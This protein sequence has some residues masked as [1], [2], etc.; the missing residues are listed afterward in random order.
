VTTVT[1]TQTGLLGKYQAIFA[2]DGFL[3]RHNVERREMIELMGLSTL[4]G[5]DPLFLGDPGVGKTWAI[6]LLTE[7]CIVDARLFTILLSKDMSADEVLGP[8]DIMAMKAGVVGRLTNGYLPVA[9][10]A[11]LDEVFKASPPLLNPLLDITANRKLKVGGTVHDCSQ[12]ITVFMSS[13]ELPDREDLTAFR[14]RIGVT[15]VVQPVKT[16]EGRRRVTDIQLDFQSSGIDTADLE[17][18]T[19]DEIGDIRVELRQVQASDIM[20]Q[21]M[22]DMQGKLLEA[23]HPPS[24]RRIGQ[25]WKMLKARAW[26]NGRQEI[27]ADDF[28]ILQHMVWNHPDDRDSG[29]EIVMEFASAHTRKAKRLQ[30]ALEPVMAE[31][32]ALR[33]KIDAATT[34]QER[35]D[36]TGDGFK[37]LRQLKELRKQGTAQL[38]EARNL[39]EDTTLIEG[40]MEEVQ[41]ADSWATKLLIGEDGENE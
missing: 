37:F 41:R 8:R 22:I 9:N 12:L 36:I 30:E 19:L 2:P 7:H 6:E 33:V 26:A 28:L 15:Y 40:V 14:D 21:Q 38:K 3:A 4:C 27:V 1:R 20:R 35:Q 23:G 10:Y 11:Y 5:V 31:L 32:E 17:P 34:D 18:L 16:P 29:R 24:Q 13:N 39:G 25:C